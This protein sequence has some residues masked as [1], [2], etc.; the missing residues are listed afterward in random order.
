MRVRE[1]RKVVIADLHQGLNRS[2]MGLCV[3]EILTRFC[4]FKSETRIRV[5]Q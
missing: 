5:I 1:Q 2:T 3:S 4:C